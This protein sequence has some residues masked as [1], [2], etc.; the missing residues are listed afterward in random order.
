[1]P[2]RRQPPARGAPQRTADQLHSAA[3][4]L[5]R[6]LRGE[7]AA[8]GPS[9][10][11]LS[12]LSVVVFAGPVTLGDLAAAEQVRPPTI[13][14]LVRE[15]ARDG[16]L[17]LVPDPDDRRIRRVVATARGRRRLLDGRRR[18]VAVLAASVAALSPAEQRLLSRAAPLIEA[19]SRP[20]LSGAPR[21]S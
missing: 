9:P 6:R 17:R 12:A 20:P 10:P 3:I 15:L 18:R 21:P 4:H 16:L 13:T 5:L 8:A 11:K 19:L 14:R 2:T 1:M 7:D